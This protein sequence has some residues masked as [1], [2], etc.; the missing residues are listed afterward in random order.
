M[1][2]HLRITTLGCRASL[3]FFAAVL[4]PQQASPAQSTAAIR[5]ISARC[6]SCHDNDSREGG[7]DLTPILSGA[8]GSTPG[9]PKL[10]GKVER[11]VARREMPPRDEDPLSPGQRDAILKSFRNQFILRDGKPHIGPTPLRRLTVSELQNTL[12][13]VLSITLKSPYGDTI[14]GRIELSRI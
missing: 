14:T 13:D 7:I 4:L 5:V 1:T 11:M 12:E 6:M 3:V 9:N 8:T 10:W 2:K